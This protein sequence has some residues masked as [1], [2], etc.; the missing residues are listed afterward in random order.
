MN[1]ANFAPL[2]CTFEGVSAPESTYTVV[3]M[4]LS[5]T[6]LFRLKT[7]T[8]GFQYEP[9]DVAPNFQFTGCDYVSPVKHDNSIR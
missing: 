7:L 1:W 4:Q 6:L 2:I 8:D 5:P 9:F 3:S